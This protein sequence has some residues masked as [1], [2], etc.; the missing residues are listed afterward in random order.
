MRSDCA[1]AFR[2]S[3]LSFSI[4]GQRLFDGDGVPSLVGPELAVFNH[5]ANMDCSRL[6]LQVDID[7]RRSGYIRKSAL[8]E[9]KASDR[10]K[11]L[12][13]VAASG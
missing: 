7:I 11:L 8:S 3:E 13:A 4:A 10:L 9:T 1:V 12:A 5:D 6:D 2:A